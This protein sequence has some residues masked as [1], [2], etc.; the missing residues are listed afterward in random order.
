MLLSHS[1]TVLFAVFPIFAISTPFL[2]RGNSAIAQNWN[3]TSLFL[4]T[5]VSTA[6]ETAAPADI[7]KVKPPRPL[8]ILETG[9]G[10]STVE[11]GPRPKPTDSGPSPSKGNVM[12]STCGICTVNV[13]QAN[14]NWWFGATFQYVVGTLTT[15]EAN[16]N[17]TNATDYMSLIRESA[18]FDVT[19]T[20]NDGFYAYTSVPYYD[21]Y[22]SE[23]YYYVEPYTVIPSAASTSV[24]TRTAAFPL[25]SG[26]IVPIT[27]YYLYDRSVADLSPPSVA[28]TGPR[29]TVSVATSS[30]P[31]L[32]FSVYEVEAAVPVTLKNGAITHEAQTQTFSL[33]DTYAYPV[34]GK[35][36]A[37]QPTV[38][39]EVPA[40]FM[41][42]IPQS[43]CCAGSYTATV[44]VL[45]VVDLTYLRNIFPNGSPFLVHIE[46]S[47]LGFETPPP[48]KVQQNTHKE[49][50]PAPETQSRNA[51]P[52]PTSP[53]ANAAAPKQTAVDSKTE[54][55][56][57]TSPD[58]PSD[59]GRAHPEV[60]VLPSPPSDNNAGGNNAP[61]IA[62]PEPTKQNV[63]TVGSVP[64]NVGPSSVVVVGSQT[65]I[66]GS[67]A[68][69]VDG[70]P[71][72]LVPSAT[73]IVIGGT[74]SALPRITLDS[75]PP[76]LLTIGSST[77]TGNAATQFLVAPGQT[78]TPGGTVT[79]GGTVVSLA[80]SA[81][82]LVVGGNT[83][84]LP[85]AAPGI[86]AAPQIVVGGNT[87]TANL[88]GSTFI[89]SGQT[90]APDRAITVSGTTISLPPAFTNVV[91]NGAT[92]PIAFLINGQMLTPGQ[93]ATL[94]GT[95]L[96][97]PTAPTNIVIN[98]ITQPLSLGPLPTSPPV[99]TLGNTPITA[100]SGPSFLINGQ[101]L[102]PGGTITVSG[103]TLHHLPGCGCECACC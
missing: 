99:L 19:Q 60:T 67:P 88:K 56:E 36:P 21:D 52:I 35:G 15:V 17:R 79:V 18:T 44:I 77:F 53:Q 71:V 89:I 97:L 68:L 80:P 84:A 58:E 32:Y 76:P 83:Q 81:S 30:T 66:P 41:Q 91:I 12:N 92:Q 27:D 74:T 20:I 85:A 13:P 4:T 50:P 90:L 102:I 33:N 38:I 9:T 73:A 70:T 59:A 37:N 23:S 69:I 57:P 29:G 87:I 101:T 39:G 34:G 31:F 40:Q 54:P 5:D 45:V 28:I 49:P 51:E 11:D 63:G 43:A 100:N 22:Y 26:D 72:S 95:T 98:G 61:A 8:P 7:S 16:Y 82:F 3:L 55:G 1:F 25:P 86:T 94:S 65:L 6:Y 78:L 46:S 62:A 64:I 24:V 47:V 96:S 75:P 10:F 103:T 48:P 93:A 42:Q 2:P 14:V